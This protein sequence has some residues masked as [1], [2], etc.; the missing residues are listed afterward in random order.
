MSPLQKR[1]Y[2]FVPGNRPERFDKA[3]ASGADAI[4]LDLEDSVP[5]DEKS[6]ARAAVIA[7]LSPERTAIIRINAAGTA[8]FGEDLALCSRPGVIGIMV[9]KSEREEYIAK[10]AEAGAASILPLIESAAGLWNAL[11]LA[12][13]PLVERLVFGSLDFS[14]DMRSGE[15]REELLHARSQLVLVSKVAG[16]APPVDGVTTALDDADVLQDDVAYARKLGFGG[17]L[18]I[19]PKQVAPVLRGFCPDEKLI[20]WAELVLAAAKA[21]NGAAIR[22]DGKMVDAPLILIAQQIAAEAHIRR[23]A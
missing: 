21:A 10:V 13:S 4:I 12:R 22:V 2:L 11:A 15:G 1:T 8:W 7:W 17:K 3:A 14:F 16:L 19:H 20:A 18:C 23:A 5:P 9:P 6:A